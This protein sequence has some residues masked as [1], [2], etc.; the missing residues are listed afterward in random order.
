MRPFADGRSKVHV[1]GTQGLYDVS[2]EWDGRGSGWLIARGR[3]MSR[4]CSR[5]RRSPAFDSAQLIHALPVV[6]FHP[7][8]RPRHQPA[9]PSCHCPSTQRQKQTQTCGTSLVRSRAGFD[10]K[11]RHPREV[12][13]HRGLHLLVAGR[14]RQARS[15]A[16]DSAAGRGVGGWH[17][18]GARPKLRL[19]FSRSIRDTP[20]HQHTTPQ[21]TSRIRV[22]ERLRRD[23]GPYHRPNDTS[24]HRPVQIKS[25]PP[26]P[27]SRRPPAIPA[28][29]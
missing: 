12:K 2:R 21:H 3:L 14:E 23:R 8:S 10:Q 28:H 13:R 24:R 16:R 1:R 25:P 27:S 22:P 26:L 18:W 19:Q 4:T 20:A 17:S 5:R 9:T 29:P 11:M 15:G 6:A 7:G